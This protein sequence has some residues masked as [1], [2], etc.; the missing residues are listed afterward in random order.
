MGR[1][2]AIFIAFWGVFY[3][4]LLVVALNN[5]L[6]PNSSQKKAL[7]MLNRLSAKD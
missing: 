4:S 1:M 6:E 3:V 5:S 7:Y 2:M